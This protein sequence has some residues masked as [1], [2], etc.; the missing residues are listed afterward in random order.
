MTPKTLAILKK[1]YDLG[2]AG[3]Q[4]LERD[5]KVMLGTSRPQHIN[6]EGGG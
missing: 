6:L 4:Y 5:N 2:R 1:T 3:I